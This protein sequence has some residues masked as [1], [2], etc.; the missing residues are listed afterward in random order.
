MQKKNEKKTLYPTISLR[1]SIQVLFHINPN[2]LKR[3]IIK[4]ARFSFKT[5]RKRVSTCFK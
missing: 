3:K 4:H 2:K 5:K 1:E